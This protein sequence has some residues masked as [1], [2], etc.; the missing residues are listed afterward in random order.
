MIRFY[1]IYTSNFQQKIIDPHISYFQ[2]KQT[3]MKIKYTMFITALPLSI[4]SLH[5]HQYENE[6]S[7]RKL[8]KNNSVRIIFKE[9]FLFIYFF[10]NL[11]SRMQ[12]TINIAPTRVI[13]VICITESEYVMDYLIN[14]GYYLWSESLYT[15]TCK[16]L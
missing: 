15:Y 5:S 8:N 10:L 11:S 14:N 4:H 1:Y 3:I 2:K 12:Q 16:S 9:I 13:T 6:H 7:S